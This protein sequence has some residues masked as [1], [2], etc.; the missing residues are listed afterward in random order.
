MEK[1]KH[2]SANRILMKNEGRE[3]FLGRNSLK[4]L[5]HLMSRFVG[6]GY[7]HFPLSTFAVI[8]RKIPLETR[9]ECFANIERLI[10]FPFDIKKR[11][12]ES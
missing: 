1:E 7:K 9:Y 4:I 6:F 5:K 12:S 2:L 10:R 8:I 11:R 3:V